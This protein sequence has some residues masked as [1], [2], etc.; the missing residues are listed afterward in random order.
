LIGIFVF[1]P[2]KQKLQNSHQFT[3][4]DRIDGR[5]RMRQWRRFVPT[6]KTQRQTQIRPWIG[7]YSFWKLTKAKI[8]A[9][10]ELFSKSKRA[11]SLSQNIFPLIPQILRSLVSE[12]PRS[13]L[14]EGYRRFTAGSHSQNFEITFLMFFLRKFLNLLAF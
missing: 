10:V 4:E 12:N 11:G 14:A 9:R 5:V 6:P 8:S 7:A 13:L 2:N 1:G 3:A